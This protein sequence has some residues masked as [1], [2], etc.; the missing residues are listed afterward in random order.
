MTTTAID[1]AHALEALLSDDLIGIG[2]EADA[3]RRR[4]HP[5]G[6]VTYALS[7][8][9]TLGAADPTKSV[10]DAVEDGATAITLYAAPGATLDQLETAICTIRHAHPTLPLSGFPLGQ[11]AALPP[12]I[13]TALY[14]AGV[15]SLAADT[16]E[17]LAFDSALAF[18]R[19]AHAAGLSTT[20]TLLFGAGESPD[21]LITRLETLRALQQ[22]TLGFVAFTLLAA[23]SPTGRDLDDP[24]AVEYLKTLA[25]C[26]IVLDNID[27]IESNWQQQ[28]LKVLQMTLRFGANDAGSLF[29]PNA[30]APEEEVRRIIRDAGFRPAQRDPLYRMCFL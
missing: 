25:L 15:R 16:T 13:L 18:H 2:M 23:H 30:Q 1:H 29:A 20:A 3:V 14:T 27:H 12:T 28:G 10:A 17:T 24:T 11:I 7:P 22:E 5:E 26:R 21:T 4:L 6:V 9:V 8:G 19:T